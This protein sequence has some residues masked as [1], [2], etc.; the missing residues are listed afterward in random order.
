MTTRDY[1]AVTTTADLK[2]LVKE[3]TSDNQRLTAFDVETGYSTP[4]PVEKRALDMYHPD[5]FVV[6]CSL[7]N[8]P[9]WAR[10]IPIRHDSEQFFE[11]REVWETLRPVLEEQTIIAHH[12]KFEDKILRALPQQGDADRPILT[13]TGHDSMLAAYVSGQFRETGLKFL[14]HAVLGEDQA[15]F[16]SLFV[17]ADGQMPTAAKV[18]RARFNHLPPTADNVVSYACDDAAL[19]LAVFNVLSQTLTPDQWRVYSLELGISSLMVEA[20]EFGVG[21]AWRAMQE[22]QVRGTTFIP[23]FEQAVRARL[24][25]MSADPRVREKALTVNFRS[26]PQMRTLLY[27]DL[28]MTTTRTTDSGALSTDAQ[29]LEALSRNH[30]GVRGLLDYRESQV[31]AKRLDKWLNEYSGACDER[32]H[33]TFSQTQ[34]VTG[35]FSANDPAIQQCPKDWLWSVEVG[36]DGAPSSDGSNGKDFWSGNFRKFIVAK[37]D[38]YLLTFDYSQIELR[39]LAGVTQEPTLLTA[40][41]NGID[42]HVATAA[43]MLGLSADNVGPKERAKGKTLNFGIIYGMG[44]KSM[45]ER[46]AISLDEARGLFDL[47]KSQFSRV[48]GWEASQKIRGVRDKKVATWLG[49]TVPLFQA[50]SDKP[51]LI[52]QAERLSV[53]APIQGGAADYVKLAMLRSRALLSAAD[54]W[55]PGKVVLTMNQH[56]A[57]TFEAHNSVDPVALRALL[58]E[59]VVFDAQVMFPDMEVP[60]FPKFEVDWEIGL[61]WGESQ[62]WALDDE[63]SVVRGDD[64]EWRFNGEEMFSERLDTS[65]VDP[66][67]AQHHEQI[68][69][70]LEP[71]SGDVEGDK[72][73]DEQVEDASSQTLVVSAPCPT[74]AQMA[75]FLKVLES[76]PGSNAVVVSF[77]DMGEV[78]VPLFT[79]LSSE[80]ADRISL[81]LPGAVV[82]MRAV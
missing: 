69:L 75:A 44:P 16:A 48:G 30:S 4:K 40:F 57:L 35:R 8:D 56:D 6:G 66:H 5:F 63:R 21:V 11:P 2:A 60:R 45:A 67:S 72:P 24:G 70:S 10:Y 82:E 55:G 7:T 59:A 73:A 46:L 15:E 50:S 28:G 1:Q 43:M 64:G 79:C 17:G 65:F 9:S 47:Y 77:G 27:E 19:C 36:E 32:V 26:A 61:S 37:E 39:V 13:R 20:E 33:P 74:E 62:G 14:S 29:A 54:L 34:V 51:G 18:K 81:T 52:A 31:L 53:N 78:D 22:A 41:A 38:H 12:K 71:L 49:R 68:V 42:P 23:R 58:Q 76:A 25:E 3:L 80:D